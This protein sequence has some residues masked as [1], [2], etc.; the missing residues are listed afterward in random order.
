MKTAKLV[1]G[2]VSIVLALVMLF[3]SCAANV[4]SVLATA[5]TDMSG[6]IGTF[7]AILLIVAGI[8]GIAARKSKGGTI[9]AFIFYVIT[10]PDRVG[11]CVAGVCRRVYHLC[12]CAALRA[13][14]Q[15]IANLYFV[16]SRPQRYEEREFFC[17]FLKALLT[18]DAPYAII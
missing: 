5:G 12:V 8:I 16:F 9:A 1:I 11:R 14:S 3:Q 4:G 18:Y 13:K 7:A 6:A 15:V 10:A 2:I 17:K